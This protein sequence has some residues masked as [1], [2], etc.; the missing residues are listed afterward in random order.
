MLLGT[1]DS[2]YVRSC[3][4]DGTTVGIVDA[5]DGIV[6]SVYVGLDIHEGTTI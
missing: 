6:A 4:T 1:V 3:S 2:T 5:V